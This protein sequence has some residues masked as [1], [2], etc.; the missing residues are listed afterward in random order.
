M[1]S[2][3]SV[4]TVRKKNDRL[5]K[6]KYGL[7]FQQKK[8][9]STAR[10]KSPCEQIQDCIKWLRPSKIVTNVEQEV[11]EEPKAKQKDK[12]AKGKK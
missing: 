10:L 7:L 3:R 11:I 8:T 4:R 12:K 6:T 9:H 2:A 5:E 1:S